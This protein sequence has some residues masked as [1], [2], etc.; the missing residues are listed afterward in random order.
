[1]NLTSPQQRAQ[2]VWAS[3]V[4]PRQAMQVGGQIT[5]VEARAA[6]RLARESRASQV[7]RR[8]AASD[9]TVISLIGFERR[10]PSRKRERWLFAW[11]G[12]DATPY[13]PHMSAPLIF[14]R[15]LVRRRLGR[16][17][18]L[19]YPDFLLARALDSLGDRLEAVVRK[20]P[21]APYNRTPTGVVAAWLR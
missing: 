6:P 9:L 5:A 15:G 10:Q 12:R 11:P 16:A 4:A 21:L 14:D 18:A 13:R 19:G 20:C 2:R 3:P 7:L 8:A 1:M 17:R